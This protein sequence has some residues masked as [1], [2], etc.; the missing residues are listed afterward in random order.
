MIAAKGQTICI[1]SGVKFHTMY[2]LISKYVFN[3]CMP[4]LFKFYVSLN[5][6]I[7]LS[8]KIS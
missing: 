4:G 5:K 6:I 8:L 2:V 1:N 7:T 3:C